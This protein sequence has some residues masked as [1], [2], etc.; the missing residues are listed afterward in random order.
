V[1]EYTVTVSSLIILSAAYR[2]DVEEA[3]A[4]ATIADSFSFMRFKSKRIK[5]DA[6]LR[7]HRINFNTLSTLNA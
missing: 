2:D 3:R 6:T 7:K 4:K 1:P 5:D